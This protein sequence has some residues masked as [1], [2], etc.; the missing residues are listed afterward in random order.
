MANR[1]QLKKLFYMKDLKIKELGLDPQTEAKYIEPENND[2]YINNPE[3]W[4]N[5]NTGAKI[6]NKVSS[7]LTSRK[8][9]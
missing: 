6:G 3:N 7:Y 5:T 2:N 8:H 9:H 1:L 4:A